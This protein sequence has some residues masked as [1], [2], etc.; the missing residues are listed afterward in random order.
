MPSVYFTENL[1]RH[2]NCDSQQ[3]N[4]KTVKQA[5]DVVFSGNEVLRSYVLDDQGRLRQHMLISIDGELISDRVRL[6]DA[7]GESSE[8]YIIQ[9]L[10]GG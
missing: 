10:S 7:I 1:K 6:T 2:I 9:A 3:V 5:L 8:I 4:A